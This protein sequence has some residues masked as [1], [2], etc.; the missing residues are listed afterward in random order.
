MAGRPDSFMPLYIGDY[1]ADTSHLSAAEHG[2]YLLMLMH[3]WR[4]G[5]LPD[6]DDVLMRITRMSKAEWKTSRVTLREF[7]DEATVNNERVLTHTRVEQELV[8]ANRR[9]SGRKAASDA[10]VAARNAKRNVQP[11]V[12]PNVEPNVEPLVN[13]PQ[14][15]S[16]KEEVP[17]AKAN[18]SPKGD[19]WIA[20]YDKGRDVFA[21]KGGSIV[22]QL[23][24]LFPNPN[25][26]MA[27]L[28][29][30]AAA[31]NP[32]EYVFKILH[33]KSKPGTHL[34]TGQFP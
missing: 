30:A 5:P 10:G 33:E 15:H 26:V 24:K 29:Q 8:E 3:Y 19:P 2:A 1:L 4:S 17:L 23:R 22:T 31:I 21:D 27:T 6:A 14:P 7:F 34:A 13:Q 11:L 16:S 20:V 18:G 9:Y 28:C 25:K 12:Q 32:S